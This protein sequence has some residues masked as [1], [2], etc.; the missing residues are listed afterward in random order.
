MRSQF[1]VVGCGFSGAVL[2]NQLVSKLDC[3]V[4]IWDERDH[5]A[6]NCHTDRD[7]ETQ[8]MVHQ[9]GPHIFNTDRKDIWDFVNGYTDFYPY[10]HRVKAKR[11]EAIFSLP[12]IFPLLP[13]TLFRATVLQLFIS[14]EL[15]IKQFPGIKQSRQAIR[16]HLNSTT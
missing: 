1:L 14:T 2:A 16:R 15:L 4:D 7:A 11:G 6:G 13:P 3:R 8:V 12:V 10:V 5:V 9:Y